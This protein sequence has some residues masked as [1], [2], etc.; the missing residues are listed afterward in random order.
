MHTL[1][2]GFTTFLVFLL[3]ALFLPSATANEGRIELYKD[4]TDGFYVLTDSGKPVVKV[5]NGLRSTLYDPNS[6]V[7]VIGESTY[8]TDYNFTSLDRNGA[9]GYY[10]ASWDAEHYFEPGWNAPGFR[11]NGFTSIRIEFTEATG[12]APFALFGNDPLND[13]DEFATE[14]FLAD[15]RYYVEPGATLPILGHAH[16]HWYFEHAGTYT[17]TGYAVGVKSDGTEVR[18]EPFTEMFRVEK[19]SNDTRP[20]LPSLPLGTPA[21]DHQPE[22]TPTDNPSFPAAP[23]PT[24]VPSTDPTKA[25]SPEPT[26]AP[27]LSTDPVTIHAGHVDLFNVS[28]EGGLLQLAAK[29]GT[30][31][32]YVMRTPESVTMAIAETAYTELPASRAEQLAP[33]GYFISENGTSQDTLPFMGW[34]TS[35]VAPDFSSINLEFLDVTGPGDIFMFSVSP[36]AG[37]TSPFSDGEY[38]LK[39]GSIINQGFPSHVHT[40]WLFTKAGT[41]TVTVKASGVP[42]D[43]G[44]AVESNRGTYTFVVGKQ[45]QEAPSGTDEAPEN[46]ASPVPTAEATNPVSSRG[47]E[48]ATLTS[49]SQ[50]HKSSQASAQQVSSLPHLAANSS[51][52]LKTSGGMNQQEQ[53]VPLRS[54]ASVLAATGAPGLVSLLM[55]ATLLSLGGLT[56]FTLRRAR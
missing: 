15:G 1:R 48:P 9:E 49:G 42:S 34:D 22:P 50:T 33:A 36:F 24:A 14:P 8:G 55:L 11:D 3:A 41:Y 10:T 2:R 45:A 26:Q 16:A 19:N 4:H 17:M 31:K 37:M 54:G 29:D 28:A 18:S 52:Q 27:T 56:I 20:D 46:S 5:A 38:Q 6:V 32:G 21:P 35:A 51:S 43:G 47:Q 53:P 25:P 12:P 44:Q 13:D 30:G 39:K 7:F 23:D 40:N